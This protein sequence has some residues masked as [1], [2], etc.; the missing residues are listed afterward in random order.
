[1]AAQF[2]HDARLDGLDFRDFLFLD[3]ETTGLSGVSV[4]A[5]LVGVGFFDGD[6]FVVRQYFLRDLDEEKAMLELL[7]ELLAGKAGLIT[8]NGGLFDLPLLDRRFLMNQLDCPVWRLPHLDLL[9]PSRRIWRA[10]LGSWAMKTLEDNVLRVRRTEDD[11]PG[12]MIPLLYMEYLSHKDAHKLHRVFYH[13]EVDVLSMVT[14]ASRILRLFEHPDT[15]QEPA[16]LISLGKWHI[17]LGYPDRA[18]TI[19]RMAAALD[20][21]L[22]A[23]HQALHE[24]GALLKRQGRRDE[25]VQLWQQIAYTTFDDVA[26]HLE[27]AKHYEWVHR[28]PAEAGNWCRRALALVES[29]SRSAPPAANARR[30]AQLRHELEGRLARLERK[31]AARL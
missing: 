15:G 3:T 21:P 10:R 17:V 22:A 29:W 24:L 16:D 12:W 13:N 6:A 9:P 23:Y 25:A 27:L 28:D 11:L 14:L 1:V 18:E 19:L 31:A 30:C 20:L 4:V 5:F 8:F 7:T 26:A 2:C